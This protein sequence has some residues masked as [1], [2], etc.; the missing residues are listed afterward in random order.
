MKRSSVN[1]IKRLLFGFGLIITL[2]V[3]QDLI[4]YM[5][6]RSTRDA[7]LEDVHSLWIS[8][9]S[10]EML[11]HLSDLESAYQ[12]FLLTG[13]TGYVDNYNSASDRFEIASNGLFELAS[14]YTYVLQGLETVNEL[15]REWK[16]GIILEYTGADQSIIL[17]EE[18]LSG[19]ELIAGI[20][21]VLAGIYQEEIDNLIM[22]QT[23][24]SKKRNILTFTI[25]GGVVIIHIIAI[26]IASW[27]TYSAVKYIKD[28]NRTELALQR[29]RIYFERLFQSVPLGVA[30][31]DSKDRII[32]INRGFTELFQYDIEEAR[33]RPINDLIVPPHFKQESSTTTMKV[34]K[35]ETVSLESVRQTKEGRLIDVAIQGQP[36]GLGGGEFSVIGVYQ[37]ITKRKKAE[38]VL[39][40]SEK[41]L[42]ELN[43]AKDKFFSII[44]HDLRD[45][46]NSLVGLSELL[47]ENIRQ[48]SLDGTEK[49][50]RHILNSSKNTFDLLSDLLSWANLQTGRFRINKSRFN[51]RGVIDE[52]LRLFEPIAR[53]KSIDIGAECQSGLSVN[54]DRT[55]IST[56]LRN[57]L[58]NAVKF[59]P[60]GGNI[61]VTARHNQADEVIVSVCDSGIGMS[62]EVI[63]NLFDMSSPGHRQGTDG[64]PGTGL[65][66]KLCNEFAGL[67]GGGIRAESVEGKGS[68]FYFTFLSG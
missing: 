44:A 58:S 45:P 60:R 49:Y 22:R 42:R 1:I 67:H 2:L 25:F 6:Y 61:K 64:E 23:E 12:G 50:A 5:N 68:E 28:R 59:T 62:P 13:D 20:R 65:G 8:G 32:E 15:Y 31:L 16:D 53:E 41:N 63:D 19:S 21:Q 54:A 47:L 48:N 35:G 34:A 43:A 7:L 57:L 29:E 18:L 10:R 38:A 11:L 4:R 17:Q 36:I 37:D 55:V 56:I 46:F 24:V 27:L 3:V 26:A 66:L 40:E 51:L 30:L 52:N 9:L 14:D 33:G 39:R